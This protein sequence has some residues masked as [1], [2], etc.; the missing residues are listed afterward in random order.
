MFSIH[1]L[2]LGLQGYLIPFATVAFVS[3]CQYYPV[4]CFRHWCSSRNQHISPLHRE[5]L[6][7]LLKTLS[8][9]VFNSLSIVEQYS[10]T[11][12]FLSHLQ[13]LYDQ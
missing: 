1:R 7:L 12:N 10:L 9:I 4:E 5:Y 11:I 6:L 13:T 8:L 2:R 3:E